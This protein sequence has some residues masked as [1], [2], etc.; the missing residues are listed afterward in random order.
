M[1]R[2]LSDN[3]KYGIKVTLSI[4]IEVFFSREIRTSAFDI[5]RIHAN[6]VLITVSLFGAET[7]SPRPPRRY[8]DP[9]LLLHSLQMRE[10]FWWKPD[11][12]FLKMLGFLP[13]EYECFTHTQ[14]AE[15]YRIPWI[16]PRWK[17]HP[18]ECNGFLFT[19][20]SPPW[21]VPLHPSNSSEL[22]SQKSHPCWLLHVLVQI[23]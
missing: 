7:L 14:Y 2:F 15:H 23:F 22:C 4:R 3:G 17:S 6:L 19:P 11:L 12:R 9:A 1:W 16:C 5:A 8:N 10:F 20:F 18:T 13:T 21:L